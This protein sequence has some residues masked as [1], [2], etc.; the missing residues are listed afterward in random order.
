[1]PL[2][3][4]IRVVD[5]DKLYNQGDQAQ[6]IFFLY[7]GRV[8]FY[9]DLYIKNRVKPRL[10]PFC[11]FV[12]GSMFGDQDIL[13]DNGRDGRDSTSIGQADC[14]LLV[15]TKVQIQKLL[16]K[17][18]KEKRQMR[19][20]AKDRREHFRIAIKEAQVAYEQEFGN[21]DAEAKTTNTM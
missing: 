5:Q 3:K 16:K 7:K 2:L 8:K 12:E 14:T 19:Q 13:I 10:E 17:F 21:V 15:L 18:P 1:M 6:E 9:F 11:L 20:M 4:Q